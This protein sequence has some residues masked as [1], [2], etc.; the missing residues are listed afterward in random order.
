[1]RHPGWLKVFAALLLLGVLPGLL[2]AVERVVLQLKW[3]HQFQ[4]AGYY[5]ARELG[6]YADAGLDVE[7]RPAVPGLDPAVEVS[8]GRAA[9]GVG[10][11]E[12]LINRH[13]GMDIVVLAAICQHSPYV[14]LVPESSG[15]RTV[16]ELAGKRIMFEPQAA[17]IE[18]FLRNEGV[19]S[20]SR[21]FHS[22]N[23]LD[24]VTGRADAMT[25]YVTTEPFIL[26]H[27]G[28]P[29]RRFLPEQ[30]GVDFYNDCLFVD[31]RVLEDKPEMV[32]QFR[33]ASLK[34][35]R[36][37]FER[38]QQ[39]I[40]LIIKK[41]DRGLSRAFLENEMREMRKLVLPELVDVG[42]INPGRWKHI[43]DTYVGL[44]LLPKQYSLEG[45]I[46]RPQGAGGSSHLQWLLVAGATAILLFFGIVLPV[47][48]INRRLREG[49]ARRQVLFDN[50]PLPIVWAYSDGRLEFVNRRFVTFF[51]YDLSE[52]PS[53]ISWA[54]LVIADEAGQATMRRLW[55]EVKAGSSAANGQ[56]QSADLAVRCRDGVR[57]EVV[58]LAQRAGG[59]IVIMFDDITE[60][61]R[62]EQ[63][64]RMRITMLT[65]E[66]GSGG[67]DIASLF[68]IDELQA[69]Q[70]S[71]AEATGVASLITTP[72]GIPVTR[73]SNFCTICK[74]I[75]R[76]T[77]RGRENCRLSDALVGRYNP[78]GPNV[79][80]CISG[81]LWDAGASITV[82]GRHIANWLVGQVRCE[83]M[84]ETRMADYAREI[85]ADPER[86]IE[87]MKQVP[88]MQEAHFRK[89][90]DFLF[91]LAKELSIKAYRNVQQAR[92]IVD[93]E[94]ARERQKE[95][96]SQL[97]QSQKLESIGTMA[98]GVAHEIN[99]PLMSMINF[100]ELIRDRLD[101]L[102]ASERGVIDQIRAFAGET[103]DEGQRI[104]GI[105]RNL[106]AFSRQEGE[107]EMAANMREIL[108]GLLSLIGR[109]LDKDEIS[110]S[111]DISPD[112]PGMVCRPRQIQQVLLNLVTNA[113][114]ALNER[115]PG[116]HPDKRLQIL[117]VSAMREGRAWVRT[118]IRDNGPGISKEIQNRIFDPFF[119]TKATGKGTGLGL[120]ISYGIVRDHGGVI[121]LESR[122][123]GP[124]FFHVWL[125]AGVA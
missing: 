10:S 46:W 76:A 42:H 53:I 41:Y 109:L 113:R 108:D 66:N 77:E 34:G 64:L 55:E 22:H 118:T 90:A 14:I 119:T 99:N 40:D 20:F 124:T 106:L 79:Q 17:E 82:G 88:V 125:P 86:Y 89:I 52:T 33:E 75:I 4:F 87:A 67:I 51:G 19:H 98:S 104:A 101:L 111:I 68:D 95:L 80:P 44:G 47:V 32:R 120:S 115:Y 92:F 27:A 65:G 29:T 25:A 63:A 15:I 93:L 117:V 31:G 105:V 60:R 78:D 103:I 49:E 61:S 48:L 70:D 9:F 39:I 57:R 13:N 24:I 100:S 74:D 56:G 16:H 11:S 7:I 116:S 23:P 69:I 2:P 91:K 43:A 54:T 12:I 107:S 81:G 102:P 122:E 97:V 18:A 73:P 72:E 21:I 84:D 96:Q 8:Q 121:E 50:S 114:D 37:A 26:S 110:V 1:M 35:W 38:P 62:A 45:F 85:G 6:Y 28:I 83:E 112:L 123:G 58:V 5:A 36:Y 3:R 71:F 59:R 30:G 94:K